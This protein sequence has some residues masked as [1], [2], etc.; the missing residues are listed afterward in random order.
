MDNQRE[1]LKELIANI[2]PVI[3]NGDEYQ[4]EVTEE[5]ARH[6]ADHLLANGVIV[7]PCKVGDRVWAVRDYK[8]HK[9]AQEGIVSEMFFTSD[10]KLMIVVKAIAR[11]FWGKTVFL[12]REEAKKALK[13]VE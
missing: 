7:P 12:S 1:K 10:M 9:H 6:I 13:G 3:F 4:V 2:P 8:G 5:Y 11:G